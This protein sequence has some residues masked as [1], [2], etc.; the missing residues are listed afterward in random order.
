MVAQ[1]RVGCRQLQEA[2]E[3]VGCQE[4]QGRQALQELQERVG[5]R[6]QVG[7]VQSQERQALVERVGLRELQLQQMVVAEIQEQVGQ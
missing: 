5:C 3:Q 6:E 7:R 2:Q 4:R 1:E